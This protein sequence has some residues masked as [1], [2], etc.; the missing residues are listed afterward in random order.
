M[1]GYQ[2]AAYPEVKPGISEKEISA[3]GSPCIPFFQTELAIGNVSYANIY[4]PSSIVSRQHARIFF[5]ENAFFI[6]D[7]GS[8]N[9]T[10][11]NGRQLI[12]EKPTILKMND[13]IEIGPY[14]LKIKP[15]KQPSD[16]V[17]TEALA[18]PEEISTPDDP[19]QK[20]WGKLLE[21]IGNNDLHPFFEVVADKKNK[22]TWILD[23]RDKTWTIGRHKSCDFILNLPK[24]SRRHASIIRDRYDHVFIKDE[25]SANG[26]FIDKYKIQE[27]T[28]IHPGDKIK[29][30]DA[31]LTL[32]LPDSSSGMDR[33]ISENKETISK[34]TPDSSLTIESKT[35]SNRLNFMTFLFAVS[36]TVFILAI[37]V[38]CWLWLC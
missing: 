24:I 11:L 34:C 2:L 12:P 15:Y 13:E 36:I 8:L 20:F 25:N 5:Q 21:Y 14:L 16:N 23:E 32:R 27:I 18:R 29:I 30:G 6:E 38:I 10:F 3:P 31:I 19:K 26:V 1:E 7:L 22:L 37:S 33:S 17:E 35:H 28:R 4:L 9:G